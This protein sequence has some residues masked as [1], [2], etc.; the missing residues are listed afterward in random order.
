MGLAALE[1]FHFLH[2]WWLA[3]LPLLWGLAAWRLLRQQ[4]DGG[5]ARVIDPDLL[6]VLRLPGRGGGGGS[7]W[8]LLVAAWTTAV[9]ALAGMTWER[10]QSVGYHAPSDWILVMDLSP[11]M[12]ATDVPPDRATR[13]RYVISDFLNAAQDTRVALVVFAG[14]A[15][16]VAPLTTD[17]ETVRALLPPLAP[18]IMPEPGDELAPALD[19]AARLIHTAAGS[20][21]QV[22]L[23]TDG[24]VDPARALQSAQRLRAQG[25]TLNVIGIGTRSGAPVPLKDGGFQQGPQ[26]GSLLSKLPDDQL[27]RIAA[28][29]GGRY[30]PA[31]ES[32]ELIDELKQERSFRAREEDA[33]T[34]S[35]HVQSWR[36]DGI[37]LLPVLLVSVALIA[38]R[39]W[40]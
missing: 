6:P 10:D 15:H 3:A 12:A 22:V 38:R 16:T 27:Q 37:W 33:Q 34:A 36:N 29:G 5:W 25:A 14:E 40:L 1:N 23:L 13:A 4:R 26:G 21:A 9:V 7:P 11:S 2:P 19:E 20:G 18:N 35:Q 28:A 24:I 30:F 39:G 32:N 17:V 8:W 31:G